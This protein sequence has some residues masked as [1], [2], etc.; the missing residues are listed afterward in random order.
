MDPGPTDNMYLTATECIFQPGLQR[1]VF[2]QATQGV[3]I[4]PPEAAKARKCPSFNR[5]RGHY[6]PP[7]LAYRA[8]WGKN[9]IRRSTWS[10][11]GGG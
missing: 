5:S 9:S 4:R 7:R 3:S 10:R 1:S 11:K 6:F 8:G 2:P